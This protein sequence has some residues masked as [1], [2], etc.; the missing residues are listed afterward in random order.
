MKTLLITLVLF[1]LLIPSAF[2]GFQEA[3]EAHR[4]GDYAIAIREIKPLAEQGDA[5]AQHILGIMYA[6]GEGVS[7]DYEEAVKWYRKAAAQGDTNA[8]V[9]L[10]AMY[11]N[12]YGVPKNQQEALQWYR[13]AAEQGNAEAQ[14]IV[15]H[16]Y[17]NGIG[18]QQDPKEASKWYK[19]ADEQRETFD[20]YNLRGIHGYGEPMDYQEVFKW[21]TFKLQSKAAK[22]GNADAEYDLGIMYELGKGVTKDSTESVKWFGKAAEHGHA[23]A[24]YKLG[25]IY[26]NGKGVPKD[27]VLAYK[28]VNLAAAQGREGATDYLK[29]I[30]KS[31][32]SAQVVEARKLSREFR[33]K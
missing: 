1:L 16:A 32:T 23:A 20:Q 31:M 21:H 25:V 4:K 5:S 9:N 10:A 12:G 6:N 17:F 19:K 8:Q 14:A 2:A 33:S 24:Q 26:Y 22:Q 18:V 3:L 13:K 28:W 7:K 27:N 29:I 15:G 30:E 11:F